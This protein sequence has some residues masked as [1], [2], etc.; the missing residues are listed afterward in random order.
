MKV[1]QNSYG[2]N[3][4]N[5]R[6]R[7]ALI[8]I[9]VIGLA[10]ACNTIPLDHEEKEEEKNVEYNINDWSNKESG[11]SFTDGGRDATH[12]DSIRLG[13]IPPDGE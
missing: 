13:I 2:T 6:K 12:E 4:D 7:N 5:K 9:I 8:G 1:K 10:A 3:R 11:E